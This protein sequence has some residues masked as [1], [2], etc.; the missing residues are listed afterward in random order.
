MRHRKLIRWYSSRTVREA[1]AREAVI[2]GRISDAEAAKLL[3]E[4]VPDYEVIVFGPDM[5]PFLKLT[6]DGLKSDTTLAGKQSKQKIAPASVRLN[7]TSDGRT[8]GVVFF[9]PKKTTVSQM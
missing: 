2:N 5:T 6:E 9:F 4:P 3:A 1:L 8:T 7:K